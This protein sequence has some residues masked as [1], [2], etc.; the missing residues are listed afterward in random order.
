MVTAACV[1]LPDNRLPLLSACAVDYMLSGF[2]Q[3]GKGRFEKRCLLVHVR[4][5][6][7]G[8]ED[9]VIHFIEILA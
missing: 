1:L 3:K 2:H 4:K 9:A 7:V 5:E 8:G 6:K